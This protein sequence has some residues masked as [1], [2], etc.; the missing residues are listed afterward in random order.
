MAR[1]KGFPAPR[2]LVLATPDLY[3]ALARHMPY[4]MSK[5]RSAAVTAGH[6]SKKKKILQYDQRFMCCWLW[7]PSR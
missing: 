1:K 7:A 4:D 2:Y 3:I 5:V 6:T